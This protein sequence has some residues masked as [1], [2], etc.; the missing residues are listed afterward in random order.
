MQGVSPHVASCQWLIVWEDNRVVLGI[1]LMAALSDPA[2][3]VRERVMETPDVIAVHVL[4]WAPVH[5][6]M[7][8]LLSTA[9]TQHHACTVEATA[10]EEATE[11][12]SLPIRGLWSGVK[13]SGPQTVDLI[14]VFSNTGTRLMAP[15]MCWVN[16]SQS[17]SKR[18][19]ANLSDTSSQKIGLAS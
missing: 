9:T 1:G 5:N 11:F 3:V 19:K 17:R 2:G 15:S 18:P 7:G 8:Q 12:R 14:P 6:P 16:T 4:L 10:K 13:D